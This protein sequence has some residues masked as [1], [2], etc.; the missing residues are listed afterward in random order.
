MEKNRSGFPYIKSKK[1]KIL[2]LLGT[3]NFPPR[4]GGD[5]A[6]INAIDKLNGYVDF[7]LVSVADSSDLN[8]NLEEFRRSYPNIPSTTYII[9]QNCRYRKVY[10]FCSR[11]AN[12]VNRRIGYSDVVKLQETMIYE[13]RFALLN[14]FYTFVNQYIAKNKID[15][16]Q[17]EF[18]FTLGWMGGITADVK[19]VFVQH[20]IQYIVNSQR[21]HQRN[22]DESDIRVQKIMRRSEINAMN[23][24]DAIITLSSNDRD[25]LIL[26]GVHT[27]IFSSFAQI[28]FDK[29]VYHDSMANCNKL[30]FIGPESHLPN[31]HG[32]NWFFENVWPLVLSKKNDLYVDIIGRW[33]DNTIDDWSKRY[34]NVNF[35]GF[36]DD[37][38][39]AIS[40]SVL[41][42]PIFQGSGI[43]MKI[44]EACNTGVPVVSSSIGAEGL[45][46]ID[47]QSA[48][49]TD[50]AVRFS[51]AILTLLDSPDT[52]SQFI[53]SANKHIES[54]FSDEKFVESR[55]QCYNY[56]IQQ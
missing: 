28:K 7:H 33:S 30:V 42:V 20:E 43:R 34:C 47:G 21:M 24:C 36:V 50:D 55:M 8:I 4:N 14:E 2:L 1:M 51:N 11:I 13:P 27:P 53:D 5:Q 56:L 38:K 16:V 10:S 46:L 48:F 19:R 15:I 18:W 23:S 26:D 45:G 12:A 29:F 41:I 25:R 32:L 35:L 9:D 17:S 49:I 54:S 52:V 39:P 3:F 31:R 40:N 22:F 6:L 37:L 44:L